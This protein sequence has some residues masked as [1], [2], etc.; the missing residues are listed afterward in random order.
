M[1]NRGNKKLGSNVF[2]QD[3]LI[4]AE[5]LEND[6]SASPAASVDLEE[7]ERED[8]EE[9]LYEANRVTQKLNV[10]SQSQSTLLS[11]PITVND[12]ASLLSTS[13][14]TTTTAITTTTTPIN[15]N[16][17]SSSAATTTSTTATTNTSKLG[18]TRT[19]QDTTKL[20]T[21]FAEPLFALHHPHHHTH[22]LPTL[23]SDYVFKIRIL[24][25]D[26]IQLS[27]FELNVSCKRMSS[28][29][30][31]GNGINGNWFYVFYMFFF[32]IS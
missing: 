16:L 19:R 31:I 8:G 18:N 21:T 7:D 20:L 28:T 32:Q 6:E 11:Y 26:N 1:T 22:H 23:I 10:L 9:Y 5:L 24:T 29:S 15:H 2:E 25:E 12:T 3:E 4:D 30:S 13:T 27:E 17:T 14:T